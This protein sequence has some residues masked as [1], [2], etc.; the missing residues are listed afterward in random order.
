[1]SLIAPLNILFAGLAGAILLLYML[2]LKRK[3]R[4]ISST[5]LWQ[6]ALRDLQANA[7][8]QRLRSSLLMWL[9]IAFILLAA[10]ALM[11]P[12]IKVLSK[13]G[14]TVAIIL[15]ASASMEASDVSPSRFGRAQAE[16][17]RLV[18]ALSTGDQATI[19][20]AGVQTR[21]VAPL[22]AD[23]STL[24]NAI[25]RAAP[26]D[27]T[28]DL[29]EAIVLATALLRDKKATQIYV[30]SDGAVP[31]INDLSV[32][33]TGVQF[34]K[35]GQGKNNLGITAMDVRRGYGQNSTPEIFVTV[36]NF[37]DTDRKIEL[38]LAHNN[39]LVVVRPMTIK[40]GAQASELFTPTNFKE[41]LFSARFDAGDDLATDD[42]AYAELEP[43]RR[44]RVLLLSDGG[45]LFLEKALGLGDVELFRSSPGDFVAT[46]TNKQYDVVV[47]DGVAPPNLPNTNQLVFNAITDFSP[48]TKIGV[49]QNPSVADWD[50]RHPV[51]RFAPWNDVQIGSSLAVQTKNWG[52]AIVEAEKTPL[53]VAGEKNGKR[54]V[55]CGFDLRQTDLPLRV[56]F[57]IFIT[58]SLRWLTARRGAGNIDGATQRA[59]EVVALDPP[60]GISQLTVV[61]PDKSKDTIP[62]ENPP[63]LYGEADKIG[64]YN[65]S[66][67]NG[68]REYSRA[69]AVSLL[70]KSESDIAPRDSIQIGAGEKIGGET[71]ARANKELWGYIALL[72]LGLLSVEWWVYHRG[73]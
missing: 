9:Q 39:N 5:L 60:T 50:K 48:V 18:N 55:W 68:E 4:V 33:K 19:I 35:I 62:I 64:V 52:R 72:A 12:A 11:R 66:G 53:V 37:S 40:A 14:Q 38:E 46:G 16:A 21:V 20:Q 49:A 6:S 43:A 24:K 15:D 34:V 23:K 41:G 32:G 2:R 54:V 73:V 28:C 36:H 30:L 56:A 13:G 57:P 26:Q 1:M 69:F 8:W 25:N 3:E 47:C 59:G 7:P 22:T 67:K 27:S 10:F 70:N 29:R 42:V 63:V 61:A 45:N 31:P 58:N 65:V 51:A 44:L 71:R 17:T